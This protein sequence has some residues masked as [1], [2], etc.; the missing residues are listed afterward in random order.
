MAGQGSGLSPSPGRSTLA[1]VPFLAAVLLAVT[2]APPFGGA[3]ARAV[4]PGRG[5]VVELTVEVS[6]SPAAVLARATS[7][8]GE[9]PPVA[10]AEVEPGRWQGLLDLDGVEDLL[11]AFEAIDVDGSSTISSAARL[12]DLGVDPAIFRAYRRP[13]RLPSDRGLDLRFLLGVVAGAAALL[14][15][16]VWAFGPRAP[17]RET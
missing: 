3:E 17:D 10:L 7:L 2:L 1:D 8:A 14:L 5:I 15:L 13:V 12:S 11:V 16:V 4:E 9:L 6:G